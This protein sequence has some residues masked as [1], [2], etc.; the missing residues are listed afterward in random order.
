MKMFTLIVINNDFMVNNEFS[1]IIKRL[2][3][4]TAAYGCIINKLTLWRSTVNADIIGNFFNWS[5][6]RMVL[7]RIVYVTFLFSLL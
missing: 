5:N 7:W 6:L 2:Q 4:G 3:F 1:S